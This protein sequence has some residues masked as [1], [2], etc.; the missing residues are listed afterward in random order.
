MDWTDLILQVRLEAWTPCP[1]GASRAM[2]PWTPLLPKSP[3]C[4]HEQYHL[5]GKQFQYG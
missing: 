4:K 5:Q 1:S 3:N 2:I